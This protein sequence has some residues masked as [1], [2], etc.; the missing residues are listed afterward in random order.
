LAEVILAKA[1]SIF[2]PKG[3]GKN[4]FCKIS[5]TVIETGEERTI[6]Q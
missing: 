1:T 4:V 5:E 3:Q 6:A 2:Y